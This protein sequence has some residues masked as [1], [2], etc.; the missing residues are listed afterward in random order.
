MVIRA[1][2]P[3]LQRQNEGVGFYHLER[4]GSDETSL[5]SSNIQ[6]EITNMRKINFLR[7]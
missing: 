7:E 5:R 3:L 2:A 6:R 4:E 1:G